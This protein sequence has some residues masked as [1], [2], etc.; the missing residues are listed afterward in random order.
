MGRYM[1][2]RE[3]SQDAAALSIA[4]GVPDT[5]RIT[6]DLTP[7]PKWVDYVEQRAKPLGHSFFERPETARIGSPLGQHFQISTT[8]VCQGFVDGVEALPIDSG[9]RLRGWG[10]NNLGHSAFSRLRVVDGEKVIRGLGVAG[11]SR[12]DI[13][14]VKGDGAMASAGWIAYARV[15]P[16]DAGLLTVFGE[17][18]G[19]RGVCAITQPRLA[20]P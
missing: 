14:A 15:S 9:V 19:G 12:P 16:E 3:R 2:D 20:E 13:A 17:M 5:P 18:P 8:G 4:L 1:A 7:D 11:P 6:Q 10:W